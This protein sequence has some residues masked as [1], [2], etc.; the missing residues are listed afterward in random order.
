MILV[1]KSVVDFCNILQNLVD[2]IQLNTYYI[3]FCI[4]LYLWDCENFYF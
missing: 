3:K 1:N 4:I 2:E